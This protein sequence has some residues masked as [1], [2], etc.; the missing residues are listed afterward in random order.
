MKS[1][2]ERTARSDHFDWTE[3]ATGTRWSGS[4]NCLTVMR[5]T[6]MPLREDEDGRPYELSS[7]LVGMGGFTQGFST[8]EKAKAAADA[9]WKSWVHQMGLKIGKEW[10]KESH[11]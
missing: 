8:L 3:D 11:V 5:I 1:R 6:Y 2:E 4:R 10:W 7:S 9:R